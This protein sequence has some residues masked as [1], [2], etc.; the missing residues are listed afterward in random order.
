MSDR[1]RLT[2]YTVIAGALAIL[3]IL[4]RVTPEQHEATL[5]AATA[6]INVAAA[7]ALAIATRNL[8]SDG[9]ANIRGGLYVTAAALLAALG[10]YGII[11]P[12]LI[13]TTL[14]IIREVL[15]VVGVILLGTA[16]AKVPLEYEP[17][18]NIEA[19]E[20]A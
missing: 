9:W 19:D 13:D 11:A 18:R 1:I 8:T 20:V 17:R 2:I 7:I 14:S 15:N 12:D 4:G 3:A 16:S 5:T 10:A 6:A